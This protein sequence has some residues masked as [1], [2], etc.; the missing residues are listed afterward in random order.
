MVIFDKCYIKMHFSCYNI[1]NDV[2]EFRICNLSLEVGVSKS[3]SQ[4]LLE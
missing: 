2:L 1:T 4:D 3:Q